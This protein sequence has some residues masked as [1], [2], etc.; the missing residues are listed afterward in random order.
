MN[1]AVVL[2]SWTSSISTR[3]DLLDALGPAVVRDCRGRGRRRRRRSGARSARAPVARR[4]GRARAS[5]ASSRGAPAGSG[6]ALGRGQ[7]RVGVGRAAHGL[8]RVVDEDV[9]RALRR[10]RRRRARRP[11]RAGA[12]R[13]RRCRSRSSQSPQSAIDAKRRAASR[14][15]R[16]VIVVCAPS[17]SSRSAMYMP[18]FARPPVSSARRP[19]RSVRASRAGAVQRR[20]GR[21]ELVVEGVDLGVL[22]LADVA[23]TRADQRARGGA[24]GRRDERDAARLVV[25]PARAPPWRWRPAPRGRRRGRAALGP[26]ALLDRLE[27]PGRG[28]ADGDGV[29]VLDGQLVELRASTSRQVSRSCGR[30]C[31]A[32]AEGTASSASI[33]RSASP[34][35][36]IEPSWSSSRKRSSCPRKARSWETATTVPSKPS[37]ACSSASEESMSRLSVG[38]SSSS[39]LW[40]SSSRQRISSRAR[41]PPDSVVGAAPRGA[42]EAVARERAHRPLEVAGALLGD[43]EHDAA[44]RGRRA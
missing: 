27:E 8:R 14:G 5:S 30:D 10:R 23:G 31:R 32:P 38:S 42:C 13:C 34:S 6:V 22:A 18:I 29:G 37:S 9:E 41:W 2:Q 4:A 25:D 1:G 28:P 7:Q 16:V 20:A 15:K 17:R 11:G 21:A 24:R 35:S 44:R 26:A 3:V 36:V 39:R 12:G 43:V 40:P 33:A 19:V